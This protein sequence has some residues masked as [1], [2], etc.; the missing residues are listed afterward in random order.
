VE[1]LQEQATKQPV[2]KLQEQA[3]KQPV[4]KLQEQEAS[5][6][7]DLTEKGDPP[8]SQKDAGT[9]APPWSDKDGK[10]Y[11][12]LLRKKRKGDLGEMSLESSELEKLQERR[13]AYNTREAAEAQRVEVA[14]AE[15]RRLYGGRSKEQLSNAATQFKTNEHPDAVKAKGAYR[16]ALEDIAQGGHPPEAAA[17]LKKKAYGQ[18]VKAAAAHYGE[19]GW[20]GEPATTATAAPADKPATTAAPA[21]ADKPAPKTVAAHK[22]STQYPVGDVSTYSPDASTRLQQAFSEAEDGV[23]QEALQAVGKFLGGKIDGSKLGREIEAQVSLLQDPED[24]AAVR[25]RIHD[26]LLEIHPSKMAA[27]ATS[28]TKPAVVR[29]QHMTEDAVPAAGGDAVEDALVQHRKITTTPFHDRTAEEHRSILESLKNL[30]AVPGMSEHREGD[31]AAAIARNIE[32]T[33]R[34]LKDVGMS[35]EESAPHPRAAAVQEAYDDMDTDD[36]EHPLLS[37]LGF[38]DAPAK[39]KRGLL[40]TAADALD[41]LNEHYDD[42]QVMNEEERSEPDVEDVVARAVSAFLPEEFSY[43][44]ASGNSRDSRTVAPRKKQQKALVRWLRQYTHGAEK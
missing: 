12:D 28:S 9:A 32:V 27:P 26:L 3:T 39:E 13:V 30:V 8:S 1:K 7:P 29:R 24:Q 25:Q 33:Q 42:W 22:A 16:A 44:D 2:E 43:E 21:P 5:E 34:I 35:E 10:R 23:E 38:D 36:E 4:E 19:H 17:A 41:I 14:A 20:P 15:A 37:D 40:Q 31:T 18:F 6:S 11:A